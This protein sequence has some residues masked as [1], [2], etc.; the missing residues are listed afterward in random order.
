MFPILLMFAHT[1]TKKVIKNRGYTTVEAHMDIN[2]VS[3]Y[4]NTASH[5]HN[6]LTKL[7]SCH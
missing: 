5:T 7:N 6:S 2:G 3:M 1:K 4:T